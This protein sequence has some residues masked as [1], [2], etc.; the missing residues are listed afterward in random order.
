[1]DHIDQQL[2]TFSRDRKYLPSVRAAVS[3]A[4]KTLN[5]YYSLTDSSEV[6]RIAMS[7]QFVGLL[8]TNSSLLTLW[9]GPGSPPSSPQAHILQEDGLGGRVDHNG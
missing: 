2:R 5:R 3:L 7:E 9:L 4:R 6:Y 8:C 1:M